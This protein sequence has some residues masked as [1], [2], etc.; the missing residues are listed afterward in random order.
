MWISGPVG[1]I[2]KLAISSAFVA[3][4]CTGLG[5]AA[6]AAGSV[7]PRQGYRFVVKADG[8]GRMAIRGLI[9]VDGKDRVIERE[10][11][12]FEFRCEAG[13][14]IAGYFEALD[15]GR[16]LQLLVFDP[17]YSKRRSALRVKGFDHIRFSWAQPGVGLRCADP[18]RGA[19]PDTT[20]SVDD[21]KKKLESLR[22]A[23]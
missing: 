19:C 12:P 2:V 23:G 11:T 10:E 15:A 8:G 14:V 4:L 13:S 7:D 3:M 9:T 21:F 18:G 1:R 5:A 16:S 17:A 22:K 20:P 6:D